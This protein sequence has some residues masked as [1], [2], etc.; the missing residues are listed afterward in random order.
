MYSRILLIAVLGLLTSACVPYGGASYY[1]TEVY[2][3]DRY[4]SGGYY[5][6]DRGYG[7]GPRYYGAPAPRYY[8]APAPRYYV[9]PPPPRHFQPSP[10]YYRQGPPPVYRAHPGRGPDPRWRDGPRREHGQ[11]RGQRGRPDRGWQR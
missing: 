4:P 2:T 9:M 7:P 1:R 8:V 3:A 5:S 6:Y 11:D 10:G